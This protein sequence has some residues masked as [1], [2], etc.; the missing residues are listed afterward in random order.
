MRHSAGWDEGKWGVG[1]V[2]RG[3]S[4]VHSGLLFAVKPDTPRLLPNVEFYEDESLEATVPW[5]TPLW[6]SHKVLICQFQYK[7]CQEKQWTQVSGGS[8][9]P[10]LSLVDGI[11]PQV[12]ENTG[13]FGTRHRVIP[14][15]TYKA[16]QA[17]L[18]TCF[19]CFEIESVYV[20]MQPVK[21]ASKP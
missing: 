19:L 1:R 10:T 16:S 15:L 20:A 8:F 5:D 6:P 21:L 14:K 12:L 13:S 2:A 3:P 11:A 4:S 7:R 18:F 17:T 9:I